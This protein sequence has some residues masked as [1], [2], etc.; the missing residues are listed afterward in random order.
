MSH[1]LEEVK[2]TLQSLTNICNIG[3][4]HPFDKERV[5]E[6]IWGLAQKG[7]LDECDIPKLARD[8]LGWRPPAVDFL[9]WT[10]EVVEV[11]HP[12]VARGEIKL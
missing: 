10:V 3:L 11:L 5:V 2:D 9:K 6:E 1:S 7:L 4:L 8:E 12:M